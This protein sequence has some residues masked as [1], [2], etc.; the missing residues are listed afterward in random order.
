MTA[1]RAVLIVSIAVTVTALGVAEVYQRRDQRR[2][3]E[4]ALMSEMR[5]AAETAL[6]RERAR[7]D[8]LKD[9]A[10][11]AVTD[12]TRLRTRLTI[13]RVRS[14]LTV[15]RGVPIQVPPV[16]VDIIDQQDRAVVVL[17]AKVQADSVVIARQDTIIRLGDR[18]RQ[19][20][21]ARIPRF[22]FRSGVAVGVAGTLGVLFLVAGGG[23]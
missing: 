17:Q 3:G 20:L 19:L 9:A 14:T 4:T 7:S 2:A 21:R 8:S 11:S 23:R 1:L 5:E 22:G 12:L 10:T 13:N 6:V 16:V 18:E 15:D